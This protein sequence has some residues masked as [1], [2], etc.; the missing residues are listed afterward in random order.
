[1]NKFL[2]IQKQILFLS[3]FICH[4]SVP[5]QQP[6]VFLDSLLKASLPQFAGVLNNPAKYK[7]QIV[8]TK[9]DRD[10]N[11][12]P[13]FTDYKLHTTKKY[14]YPASTVKLPVSLLA[15]IKLE[16]LN[17]QGLNK[18]TAM[19]A[20]SAFY[21][22][23]KF[24]ADPTSETG[25][26]TIE[27]YIRK[28]FLVSDNLACAR[29][30]DFVGFDYAH[31]KL[32]A[33]GYKNVRL[34]NKLDG[35]C[36]GDTAKISPPIYFL[37]EV[38][39]TVY[40]QPLT[41]F[42]ENLTHPIPDSK[43]G[44]AIKGHQPKDFSKHNYMTVSDLHSMMRKIIFNN[45][46]NEDERLPISDTSRKFMIKYLGL[47]PKESVYPKYDPKIYYD[48]FKK[49]FLYGSAVATIKQDSIRVINIVG[50]AYGFLIDCA[51]IVDFKNNVE[52]LLTGALY[53]NG[54]NTFGTGR[55]EYDNIG[56]P[57]LKELGWSIY[58]YE[59]SRKKDY[60]PDLREIEGLFK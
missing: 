8:Y 26:P 46:L 15:L 52:Y 2:Q 9:I 28:M 29:V 24:S 38:K 7:L 16:E 22:Q 14:F 34:L 4:F 35:Q 6:A 42:S 36:P 27:N 30:Y 11:N 5:A 50:R 18:N 45:Y 32:N 19:V 31:K 33:W 17:I 3:F 23:K 59:R 49:Y 47:Y 55:Y 25:Y 37:S 44:R 51:Y 21:C 12:K 58:T 20:D 40:K 13:S 41:F 43:I 60:E 48:S 53:V 1:M 39:D 10:K 54:R 56:L 57:F